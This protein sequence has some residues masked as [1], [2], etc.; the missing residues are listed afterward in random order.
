MAAYQIRV[1]S[2]VESTHELR[3]SIS[4]ETEGAMGEVDALTADH[5]RLVA[6]DLMTLVRQRDPSG[7]FVLDSHVG[8]CTAA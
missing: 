2:S 1:R 5:A 3:V 6:R 7:A 8:P 4:D